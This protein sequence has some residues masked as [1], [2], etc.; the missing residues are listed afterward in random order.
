MSVLCLYQ[1]E[2][3]LNE[4]SLLSHL[5][6]ISGI[7]S[8]LVTTR[9]VGAKG[10]LYTYLTNQS[11]NKFLSLTGNMPNSRAMYGCCELPLPQHVSGLMAKY[12]HFGG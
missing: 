9:V 2:S 12:S 5:L 11:M 7:S 10:S 8:C 3:K 4:V 1:A 6:E